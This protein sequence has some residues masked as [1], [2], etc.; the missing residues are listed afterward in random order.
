MSLRDKI[1]A[2]G[3]IWIGAITII[4]VANIILN[5]IERITQ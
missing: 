5:T 1:I 2:I 4:M 3:M